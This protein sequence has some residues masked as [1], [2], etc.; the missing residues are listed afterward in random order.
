MRK[1]NS[2]S[3][4]PQEMFNRGSV[5]FFLMFRWERF[6]QRRSQP[7]MHAPASVSFSCQTFWAIIWIAVNYIFRRTTHAR[8]TIKYILCALSSNGIY[9]EMLW[10][11]WNF[12]FV[13]RLFFHFISSIH[14]FLAFNDFFTLEIAMILL[15]ALEKI[16]SLEDLL[17]PLPTI[18]TCAGLF[19][20]PKNQV[21]SSF[22]IQR[23]KYKIIVTRRDFLQRKK[24]LLF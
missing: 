24:I 7:A 21:F 12:H 14:K 17:L 18:I 13:S 4:K 23:K 19:L 1:N 5:D 15:M 20:T 22:I 11:E 6:A 16:F 2:S 10:I 9:R 3:N 8:V